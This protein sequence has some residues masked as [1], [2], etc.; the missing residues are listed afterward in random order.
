MKKTI[1]FSILSGAMAG[2]LP[3]VLLL[4]LSDGTVGELL[5]VGIALTLLFLIAVTLFLTSRLSRSI[6]EPVRGMILGEKQGELPPELVPLDRHIACQNMQIGEQ[7]EELRRRESEFATVMDN[8]DEGLLLIDSRGHLLSSNASARRLLQIPKDSPAKWLLAFP[9]ANTQGGL[10]DPVRRLARTALRGE[11]AEERATI[12]T[13]SFRLLANPVLNEGMVEGAVILLLNETEKEQREA[14]RREFTANV[15]H[16]LKTPLTA[17][18]GFAELLASR[19]DTDK[20][21][22][23]A[24]IIHRESSRLLTLV[25]DILALSRIDEGE[26]PRD[27]GAFP[28][29]EVIEETATRFLPIAE[30]KKV[31]LTVTIESGEGTVLGSRKMLCDMLGNLI[32]NAIKYARGEGERYVHVLLKETDGGHLLSVSDNGIGIPAPDRERVFERFYRVDKSHSREIGGT[33][34]GLSIV[35]RGA[36]YHG[37]RISL[38]STVGEGTTVTLLFPPSA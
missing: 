14:L 5:L 7:M 4:F 22:H 19:H 29:K 33:G 13:G 15:S 18:S 1:F 38:E 25:N 36:I 2:F 17:I 6:L 20:T 3:C 34:L 8:M 32:D 12:P 11:H 28:L 37:A 30:E 26:I 31:R 24:E 10:G 23:F 27:E 16:E 35:K 21:A 9:F